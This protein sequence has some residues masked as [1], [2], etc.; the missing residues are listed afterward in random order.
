LELF[1]DEHGNRL[2]NGHVARANK[3]WR[4]IALRFM[5]SD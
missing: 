5:A 2:L 3:Q 1:E 4:K